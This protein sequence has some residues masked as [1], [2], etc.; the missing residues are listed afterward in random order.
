MFGALGVPTSVND[1]KHYR[2]MA[3]VAQPLQ[4]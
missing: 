3:N 2:G 4:T 1:R